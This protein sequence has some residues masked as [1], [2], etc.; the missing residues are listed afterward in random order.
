M[1]VF[2]EARQREPLPTT[3]ELTVVLSD[4]MPG[5][6]TRG[7]A[8]APGD[9][10]AVGGEGDGAVVTDPIAAGLTQTSVSCGSVSGG[11]KDS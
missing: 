10:G 1:M 2:R 11:A 3:E 7:S 6:S 9:G 4:D 8:E 5:L